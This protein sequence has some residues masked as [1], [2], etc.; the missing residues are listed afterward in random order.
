MASSEPLRLLQAPQERGGDRI[1]GRR[2]AGRIRTE[3]SAW[4]RF[5]E[6]CGSRCIAIKERLDCR[7]HSVTLFRRHVDSGA[8]L[9]SGAVRFVEDRVVVTVT[10]FYFSR[11]P[12][13]A[14]LMREG[15]IGS[16]CRVIVCKTVGNCGR[17]ARQRAKKKRE[18][19]PLKGGHGG[20][21]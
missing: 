2:G 9:P 8:A 20:I 13:C 17:H 12:H 11:F 4:R 16:S 1:S 18:D 15:V 14:E 19:Q 5:I 21:A 6:H 10:R 3:F 7:R